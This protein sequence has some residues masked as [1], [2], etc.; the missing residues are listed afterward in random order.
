MNR[1]QDTVI[2]RDLRS[3]LCLLLFYAHFT[4]F[5]PHL[6]LGLGTKALQRNVSIVNYAVVQNRCTRANNIPLL[7]NDYAWLECRERV[8]FFSSAGAVISHQPPN[9]TRHHKPQ[10]FGCFEGRLGIVLTKEEGKEKG[11][12][13]I[14][15]QKQETNLHLARAEILEILHKWSLVGCKF[16]FCFACGGKKKFG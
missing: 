15:N 1:N 8:L 6:A 10:V 7:W 9:E 14:K 3:S 12:T 11:E 2:T 4:K 13:T 5:H 16:L